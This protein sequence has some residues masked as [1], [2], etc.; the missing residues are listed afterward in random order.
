MRKAICSSTVGRRLAERGQLQLRVA[1]ASGLYLE[2]EMVAAVG[3]A[4]RQED[5][6]LAV[7]R[8]VVHAAAGLPIGRPVFDRSRRAD[9][10]PAQRELTIA[11]HVVGVAAADVVAIGDLHPRGDDKV[12]GDFLE[13]QRPPPIVEPDDRVGLHHH[14]AGLSRVDVP[15]VQLVGVPAFDFVDP[16]PVDDRRR[17]VE[18]VAQRHDVRQRIAREHFASLQPLG[19]ERPTAS[20]ASPASFGLHASLVQPSQTARAL[21]RHRFTSFAC[22]CGIT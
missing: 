22:S 6:V 1:V 15:D 13:H 20:R 2:A 10:Q 3:I 14:L 8:A 12:A 11:R 4:H 16:L 17:I 7:V 5:V 21:R 19:P 18:L 9:H